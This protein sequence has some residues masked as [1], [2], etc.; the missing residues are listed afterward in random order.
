[1][2]TEAVQLTP[3]AKGY[4]G[5]ASAAPSHAIDAVSWQ[6]LA[7]DVRAWDELAEPPG[8][9]LQILGKQQVVLRLKI[10]P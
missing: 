3:N 4:A 5:T 2:A 7:K 6:S 10:A 8:H 1:M 9:L